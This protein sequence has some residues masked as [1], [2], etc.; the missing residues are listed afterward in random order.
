MTKNYDYDIVIVGGGPAGLSAGW[1]AAKKG[2][3]VAILERDEAI[4]QSVRTSGVTWIK[5][6]RSFG[7]PPEYYNPVKNYAFYSPSNVILK[8]SIEPEVAV[9]DVRKT[10]QFLAYEAAGAGAEIFLRTSVTDVV[11][12]DGKLAGVKATSLKEDLTFHSKVV[13]DASGFYSVVGK[14]RGLASQWK[15]FGA[16]AEY[17][18]YV[19][20]IDPQTWYLMVGQKYSP[21]GYAWV[22]PLGGNKVRIGVGI[23]KPESQADATQKLL[24]L[25]EKRPKPLDELGR[26]VPVEFHY[27]LIPNEGLRPSTIDDNLVLVGDSA[28]QANPLV[29]EGI[30]YAIEFGRKAGEVA[31]NAVN[32]GDTSRKS[33]KPYEDSMRKAIGSKIASAIKVQY[34]WL[35][36]SDE[37][38]DKEIEIIDDLSAEEFL[39]FVKAEFGLANMI[40]LAASHPKLAIRQL[41]GLIKDNAVQQKEN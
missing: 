3:K 6:A 28:G 16:G 14:A 25:L 17:E 1:S 7:I 26:I 31:A 8:K 35:G 36:L 2:A 30:R 10:Y 27:G 37:E 13:I 24:E 41:F 15:R 4:G 29:L 39:D 18:A 19:E 12:R 38:W 23:G 11:T 22:F 21:A 20:K 40:K 34:R 9:L 32:S 33:L 5:E